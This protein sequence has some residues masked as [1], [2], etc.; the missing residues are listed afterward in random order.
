MSSKVVSI[1]DPSIIIDEVKTYI[2]NPETIAYVQKAID[3][4]AEAHKGQYRKSGEPYVVH[5]YCVAYYLAQ[6]KLS[7]TTVVAGLLH[8]VVEDTGITKEDISMLFGNEV[9]ELVESLT[10]IKSLKFKNQKEYE[11][12]NHRKIVIALANDL[13]VILIKLCDRLHNMR[14]L[15]FQ[16]EEK[17]KRIA[18]ETLEVYAPIAHRLG[19]S[20]IKNEL[21]DLSFMYLDNVEYHHIAKLV[22]NKKSERDAHVAEMIE[23][24]TK[25]LRKKGFKFRIFGRSKHL[26]SIYKKM[27]TKNKRFDEILDLLAIRI[28]TQTETNCY[29]ILGYIHSKY[30]PIPGRLKD[31]IA[32]PKP[33]MYQ[34]LHTTVVGKGGKIFEIQIRT[35][36]MDMVADR[37]VAAHW[38]YKE[39]VSL[40]PK[41]EQNKLANQL[42]FIK[43]VHTL[44]NEMS[45]D[46]EAGQFMD[47][48]S[49][50]FFSTNVYVMTPQ[51]R[52]I[53]LPQG[54]T[55]IDFAYR[56]HTDVG[57][58]CIGA[59]V[60]DVMVPLNT[61]LKTGDV[62]NI[63]TSKQI[64]GPSED[65]LKFVKTNQAKSKIK[66]FLQKKEAEAR[67]QQ[68]EQGE[69]I[70][71]NELKRRNFDPQDYI[72][73]KKIDSIAGTFQVN[74]YEE[75]MYGIA[76]KSISVI[77]VIEKLTNQKRSLAESNN[78]AL[79]KII[80]NTRTVSKRS[81]SSNGVVVEGVDSI[82]LSL[83]GCCHPV[84]G[85]EIVGFI[86][87]GNGVKVH[88]KDCP[89]VANG[90]R[91]ISVSWEENKPEQKY[92]AT[93]LIHSMDRNFLLT[94]IVTALSA[95]KA[96]I[97]FINMAVNSDKLTTTCKVTIRVSDIKHLT[98]VMSNLKKIDSVLD[99]VR[100]FD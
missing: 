17:Q 40:D 49:S 62:I 10:K 18:K 2:S 3:C 12:E 77:N 97:S 29:E 83:A 44:S 98:I 60:N 54:S 47:T 69:Q 5:V 94:D 55:C 8:D 63:K 30:R 90:N 37:G 59:T 73:K 76:V 20:E 7:P 16:P 81:V 4:A 92:D 61:V 68:V 45:S 23:E 21:E 66:S 86:S 26:Y 13:R 38:L 22:E 56:V 53:D 91:L 25:M 9:A 80:N 57:H 51:G 87:K 71:T 75:L 84:Y 32:V 89:N 79:A 46:G 52:V 85:D 99:V 67:K 95:N 14:T 11:A 93:L 58:S 24:I 39:G 28:V 78:E 74:N 65:W 64:G 33:N 34:S 31:Y 15:K 35:E 43:D 48:L 6:M 36:E 88:R 96:E 42:P 70:L 72:D 50:D 19:M 27:V 1:E 41:K 100:S 82:M